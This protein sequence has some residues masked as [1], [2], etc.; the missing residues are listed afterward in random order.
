MKTGL[1]LEGGAKR[2]IYT[3]GVLDVLNEHGITVDGVLGVSAGAIHGCS[4]VAGQK[5]RSIRY[6]LKY[7]NDRRFMSF[8]SLLTTGDLVGAE[9][10]YHELP[11]KLDPFN[12]AAFEK[13]ATKFYV[14]CSNLETGK[15]DYIYCDE[16][17]RKM[18][19]LRA[20]ASLPLVSRIVEIAGKK[21]LDGGITDSIPLAAMQKLGYEKNI[22]VLTRPA[23]Y[24][25]KA[26]FNRCLAKLIYA[27]YPKFAE[28]IKN[29]HL[30]YNRELEEIEALEKAGKILVIRP[31]RKIKIGKMERNPAVVKEMYD[32]GVT[33][34]REML[35]NIRKFL[36]D[37]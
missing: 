6:T 26:S 19:Y 14:T 9:F 2:G 36:A 27:K 29:R 28:A 1:V 22:V 3:A 33:D 11:E 17:R 5:G 31:S 18:D 12:H 20:S 30:M 23:G 10:C 34:A 21:Y 13:S 7:G 35:G 24:R 8:Y 4:Y 16:L 32:L 37:N 15:A 25:K